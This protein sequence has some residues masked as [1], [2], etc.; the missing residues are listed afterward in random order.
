[1]Q[2]KV[3]SSAS[4]SSSGSGDPT[5]SHSAAG[6]TSYVPNAI[7]VLAGLSLSC[8][9][10]FNGSTGTWFATYDGPGAP[11]GGYTVG[12]ATYR[13]SVEIMVQAEGVLLYVLDT[14]QLLRIKWDRL[15]V[16]VNGSLSTTLGS[17]SI[18]LNSAGSG[19][20]YIPIIGIP[21]S[22]S[23]GVSAGRTNVPTWTYNP[24][25]PASGAPIEY[26][27][28]VTGNIYGGWRY[29]DENNVWVTLP[30]TVVKRNPPTGTGCP[31][32]LT[33]PSIGGGDTWSTNADCESS[34]YYKFEYVGRESPSRM[35][36]SI[37]C[38][39]SGDPEN[40]VYGP[41]TEYECDLRGLSACDGVTLVAPQRDV[42]KT[43]TR[44]RSSGGTVLSIYP[45]LDRSIERLGTYAAAIVRFAFPSVTASAGR[46]CVD[47]STTF[48]GSITP[49]VY[50]SLSDF[51]GVLQMGDHPLLEPLKNKFEMP[52]TLSRSRSESQTYTAESTV[53]S[54]GP[55]PGCPN[56]ASICPDIGL[57]GY[58]ATF[59]DLPTVN[60][61]E[62]IS[63]ST[64]NTVG[65]A[66]GPQNHAEALPRYVA[67]WG[68][69]L[70]QFG[71]FT[72][73]W[74]VDGSDVPYADYWGPIREQFLYS[75]GFSGGDNLLARNSNVSDCGEE[76]AHTPWWDAFM[77]KLRP[78]GV[79]KWVTQAR[80]LPSTVALDSTTASSWDSPDLTPP[81]IAHGSKMTITAP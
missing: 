32:G 15:K 74:Q 17:S 63:Y 4:P 59:T 2:W 5:Y 3:G 53:I 58:F 8:G 66:G 80:A 72:D 45:D 47:G 46:S 27:T 26:E 51:G 73:K 21:L 44:G 39:T 12:G 57:I 54:L 16:Y 43:T 7:N 19:P 81:T 41:P 24:C 79:H 30:V 10:T 14:G 18:D 70:W 33:L 28:T 35:G 78:L 36:V 64:L 52:I 50:P 76:S 6:S 40:P 55:G 13:S 62:S 9:S 29:Q 75:P 42:Y 60:K 56:V 20:N 65:A 68:N 23:G 61:S 77:G 67:T 25:N 71:L 1:M 11:F 37:S 49:E 38:N 22:L 34:V 69:P 48:A 31:Y